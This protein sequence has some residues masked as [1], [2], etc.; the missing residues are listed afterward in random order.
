MTTEY[1]LKTSSWCIGYLRVWKLRFVVIHTT[2]DILKL[3]GVGRTEEQSWYFFGKVYC[4]WKLLVW[5]FQEENGSCSCEKSQFEPWRENFEITNFW[6]FWEHVWKIHQF[7][8]GLWLN[9][10]QT[11]GSKSPQCCKNFLQRS[12]KSLMT[13]VFFKLWT[14]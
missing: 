3:S 2:F 4:K 5:N 1:S 6:K 11:S 7:F 9:L 12:Q 13:L 14:D 8:F 10:F